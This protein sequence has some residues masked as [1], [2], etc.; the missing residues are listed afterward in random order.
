[1]KAGES[2]PGI[3]VVIQPETTATEAE[4]EITFPAG[5]TVD[6]SCTVNTA[7]LPDGV[8]A[9]P[10]SGSLACAG[11]S[12]TV[13]ITNVS[14]LT[15]SQKYGVN[16]ATGVD[17]HAS[18]GEYLVTVETLTSGAATIDLTELSTRVITDDQIVITAT[19]PPSF[20][21]TLSA[22]SDT[23]ISDLDIN[24]VVSSNGVSITLV[25]N[26][27]NGW[28][29]FMRSANQSLD[30]SLTGDT[31]PT[32]G[33]VNDNATTTLTTG[34]D[35]YV[36]DCDLTTDSVDPDSGTV[37]IDADY[38]HAGVD[39]GGTLASTHQLLA[40]ADG[41]TDSDVIT[42]VARATIDELTQAADDYTDT[43]TVV[44]AGNF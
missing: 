8:T 18:A 14:D 41:P 17:L 26:G 22:N 38:N 3:L 25:T 44:G 42:L 21:F 23:F 19:T 33:T 10:S 15:V 24:S 12:Q 16:I 6:V 34:N 2:D 7:N 13:S 4:V 1:M 28:V 36:V 32:V 11:A 20:N 40:S 37:T 43:L 27:S 35:E 39:G 29:A 31:I 30:S 5:F 9:L